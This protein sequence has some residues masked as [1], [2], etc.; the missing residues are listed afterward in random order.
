MIPYK[1]RIRIHV[2]RWYPST[3]WK[4]KPAQPNSLDIC[5]YI[6]AFGVCSSVLP[7]SKQFSRSTAGLRRQNLLR[8]PAQRARSTRASF[9]S[10]RSGLRNGVIAGGPWLLKTLIEL[11]QLAASSRAEASSIAFA[12]RLL[13]SLT[14]SYKYK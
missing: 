13:R 1:K 12:K 6:Q 3:G 2:P 14:K 4:L 11:P 7:A 5:T 10:A 8:D 9:G